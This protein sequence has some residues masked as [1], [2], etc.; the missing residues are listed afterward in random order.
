MNQAD[1]LAE[2]R[3]L[4]S[5][6]AISL[7]PPAPGWWV[8]AVLVLSCIYFLSR[9]I[10]KTRRARAYQREAVSEI[11]LYW[12]QYLDEQD[13]SVY[14]QNLSSLLKRTALS[15]YPNSNA[16][17]TSGDTWLAFLDSTLPETGSGNRFQ[18]DI[19]Q[20]L[21]T[22]PYRKHIDTNPTELHTL[23]EHWL[24]SHT[25]ISSGVRPLA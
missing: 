17:S 2:L 8:L 11:S 19:G 13:I 10:Q 5:P 12:Q 25:S 1:P 23:A 4:A 22:G 18:S 9:K 15:A 20:L 21:I 14:L 6:D 7:W 16:A 3:A 24:R